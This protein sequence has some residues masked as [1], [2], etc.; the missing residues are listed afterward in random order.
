M[1]YYGDINNYLA[2]HGILG[3][4]WGKRNG[5]PYPLGY[6]K[7]SSAEKKAGWQNSLDRTVYSGTK[8]SD[9]L[10]MKDSGKSDEEI[11]ETLR[12][13]NKSDKTEAVVS[14][15]LKVAIG[16]A[17]LNPVL[18][19]DAVAKVGFAAYGNN[20][21][22][23]EQERKAELKVDKETG[24]RLKNRAWTADE[25]CKVVNP[26]V[27]NFDANTKNN[28]VLCSVAYDMRRRGYDV[29]ANK[30]TV[31]YTDKSWSDFYPNAKV[32]QIYMP[33]EGSKE[34][35]L[36]YGL[37]SAGLN[38]K[39]ATTTLDAI[40]KQG[41]GAR[42]T[43]LVKFDTP[44]SGHSTAYEVENGEVVIRDCQIGKTF[45]GKQAEKYLKN[46]SSTR[47]VRLDNLDFDNKKIKEAVT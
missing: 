9:L 12:N 21:E 43:I 28:C 29:S 11:L 13:Q 33:E 15:A 27:H 35:R 2:H 24:M 8:K 41:D 5:P 6:E 7:H 14:T 26:A 40:K 47:C 34:L 23:K 22:K 36:S 45:K 10:K 31:G 32:E 18:I 30:A 20:K 19:G 3:Q 25:D 1:H 39:V 42:G 44:F 38:K 4:K 46:C 37:A 17:T 16:L